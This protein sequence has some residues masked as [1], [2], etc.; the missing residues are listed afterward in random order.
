MIAV[1]A[2]VELAATPASDDAG[3][4]VSEGEGQTFWAVRRQRLQALTFE[5]LPSVTRVIG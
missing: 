5:T 1:Y 2:P 4:S 3:A